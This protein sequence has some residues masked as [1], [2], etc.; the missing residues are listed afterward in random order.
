[1]NLEQTI[2]AKFAGMSTAQLIRKMERASSSTNLDDET[3]ELSR[4]VTAA[5]DT[6]HWTRDLFHPKIIVERQT[7]DVP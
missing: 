3:Y 2:E 1:M 7:K 6:W 4:R 5:G